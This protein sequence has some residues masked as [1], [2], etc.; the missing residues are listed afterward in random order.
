MTT[1]YEQAMALVKTTVESVP[2]I[3]RV[4]SRLRL[5]KDEQKLYELFVTTIDDR[6]QVRG[7]M[8]TVGPQIK[9]RGST[10]TFFEDLQFRFVGLMSFTDDETR[11]SEPEFFALQ[12]VLADTLSKKIKLGDNSNEVSLVSD[13]SLAQITKRDWMTVN[14]VLCHTCEIEQKV[15]VHKGIVYE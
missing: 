2:S 12:E 4:H 13:A 9:R 6:K 11:P 1:Q 8:I 15:T 14:G 10:G 3:G 5:S 7:W